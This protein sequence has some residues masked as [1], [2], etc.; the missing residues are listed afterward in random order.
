M[1]AQGSRR[2]LA[3]EFY[4]HSRSCAKGRSGTPGQS[5]IEKR[6]LVELSAALM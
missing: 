6:V 5:F 3:R 2:G 1:S 4:G